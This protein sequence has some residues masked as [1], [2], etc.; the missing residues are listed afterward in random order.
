VECFEQL[1]V[2]QNI[3][4]YKWKNAAAN[5]KDTAKKRSDMTNY[6][7]KCLESDKNCTAHCKENKFELIFLRLSFDS[8]FYP[9]GSDVPILAS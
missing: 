8:K 4:K 3:A 6:K 7:T 2:Q 1:E 5:A 9:T